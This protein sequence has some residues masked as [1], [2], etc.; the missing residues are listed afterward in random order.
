MADQPGWGEGTAHADEDALMAGLA[1]GDLHQLDVAGAQHDRML[2]AAG[3]YLFALSVGAGMVGALGQ[4][5]AQ[6]REQG[7]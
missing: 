3:R 6:A 2:R 7:A 1:V 5:K 4:G